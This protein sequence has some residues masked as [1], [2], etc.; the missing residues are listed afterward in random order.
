MLIQLLLQILIST[1]NVIFSWLP[2]VDTLPFGIDS[3][4]ISAM[5]YFNGA[6]DT[7]PYLE[8]VFDSFLYVIG[9][10]VL[11]LVLKLFLGSRTPHNV[12]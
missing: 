1:V 7:L 3:A 9:F 2:A 8:I 12:N 11:L 5:M 4:F 6:I 10:E